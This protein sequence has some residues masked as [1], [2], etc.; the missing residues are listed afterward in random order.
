M[1]YVGTETQPFNRVGNFLAII[2]FIPFYISHPNENRAKL[3]FSSSAESSSNR[4]LLSR[5]LHPHNV[6][7]FVFNE[8]G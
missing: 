6:L 1:R 7:L 3:P 8:K 5:A 4:I 2:I